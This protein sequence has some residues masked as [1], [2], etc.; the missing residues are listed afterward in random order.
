[1]W[2]VVV[3]V[4]LEATAPFAL[5]HLH[6]WAGVLLPVVG[7]AYLGELANA[8]GQPGRARRARLIAL[9]FFLAGTLGATLGHTLVW[10]VGEPPSLGFVVRV[11]TM[12]ALWLSVS[13]AG[14]G[15]FIRLRHELRVVSAQRWWTR[16][17]SAT[18]NWAAQLAFPSGAQLVVTSQGRRSSFPGF[19]KARANLESSGWIP[20]KV[21]HA[22]GL[23]PT[24]PSPRL[25]GI[26][27]VPGQD[28]RHVE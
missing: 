4:L 26:P 13:M 12:V 23:I 28:T 8:S 15:L 22:Q 25:E 6:E 16:S 1:V 27:E 14:F 17:E 19:D 10:T 5:R 11:A 7:M 3:N 20:A 2:A 18:D 24:I 9:A 21:A